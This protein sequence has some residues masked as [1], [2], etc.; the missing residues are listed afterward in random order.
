ML[1]AT[2]SSRC[3]SNYRNLFNLCHLVCRW[4]NAS[5]TFFFSYG[6]IT[7]TLEDVANQLLLPILGDVDSSNIKLSIEGEAVEAELR[8]GM[9]GNTKLS[10]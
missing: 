6:E 9:N 2:V 8:K 1:K 3:L 10:F 5:Y 7:V 4:C